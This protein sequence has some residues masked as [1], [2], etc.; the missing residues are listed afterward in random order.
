MA[1]LPRP[2]SLVAN[3]AYQQAGIAVHRH[4]W[5][6]CVG[7]TV[8][9][10][11]DGKRLKSFAKLVKR[12]FAALEGTVGQKLSVASFYEGLRAIAEETLAPQTMSLILA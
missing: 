12:M 10:L 2:N 6:R 4:R 9:Q 11:R 8:I 7:K 1:L 5:P 3:V